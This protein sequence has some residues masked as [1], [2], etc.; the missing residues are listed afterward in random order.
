MA[1]RSNR[2]WPASRSSKLALIECSAEIE[3]QCDGETSTSLTE[4]RD[5]AVGMVI[6]TSRLIAEVARDL[7]F[8]EG[9]PGNWVATYR[10]EHAGEEPS[11]TANERAKLRELEKEVSVLRMKREFV[12]GRQPSSRKTNRDRQ[13]RGHQRREGERSGGQD[14]PLAGGDTVG[15]LR[16]GRPV[17]VGRSP[18]QG[19]DRGAGRRSV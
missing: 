16:V 6:E 13:V 15:A 2:R 19:P 17:A 7:G 18:S 12:K 1:G 14:V 8:N 10:R 4:Y 11:M 5:E 3:E 9:T